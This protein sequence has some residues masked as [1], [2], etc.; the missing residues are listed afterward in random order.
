MHLFEGK[1]F[2][3]TE[4]QIEKSLAMLLVFIIYILQAIDM[5]LADDM[6]IPRSLVGHLWIASEE[7]HRLNNHYNI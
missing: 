1:T 6:T 5:A 2:R 7:T 3:D 4:L